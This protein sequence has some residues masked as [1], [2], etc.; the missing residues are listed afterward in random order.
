MTVP[1]TYTDENDIEYLQKETQSIIEQ[2]YCYDILVKDNNV[3]MSFRL[4]KISPNEKI[5]F[6]SY[7]FVNDDLSEINYTIKSK[8]SFENEKG[9]LILKK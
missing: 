3:Y 9:Q 6:P 5:F 7:I 8:Y 4:N 2:K 1:T